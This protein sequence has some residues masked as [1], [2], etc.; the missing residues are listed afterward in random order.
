MNETLWITIPTNDENALKNVINL[1][2]SK[3]LTDLS[4]NQLI[5]KLENDQAADWREVL[6]QY[7]NIPSLMSNTNPSEM[8][9]RSKSVRDKFGLR[10]YSQLKDRQFEP[11]E[12]LSL[13]ILCY[14]NPVLIGPKLCKALNDNNNVDVKKEMLEKSAYRRSENRVLPSQSNLRLISTAL[15]F[16]D[17]TIRLPVAVINRVKNET[18]QQGRFVHI[19]DQSGGFDEWVN[20][21]ERA[22]RNQRAL[23]MEDSYAVLQ[24]LQS[25]ESSENF[26]STYLGAST[27]ALPISGNQSELT[28]EVL[29]LKTTSNAATSVNLSP[30]LVMGAAAFACANHIPV[31]S[32]VGRNIKKSVTSFFSDA[33]PIQPNKEEQIEEQPIFKTGCN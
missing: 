6:T 7:N 15:F 3:N 28:P 1:I 29:A 26:V 22:A 23:E 9:D 8:L 11:C 19:I 32:A 31:I 13:I 17:T 2:A 14:S 33:K 16:N 5:E 20:G 12:L 25:Y 18:I 24:S 4:I 30:I 27:S 21:T 10:G